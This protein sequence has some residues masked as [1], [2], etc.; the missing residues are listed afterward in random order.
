MA[1]AMP[2]IDIHFIVHYGL[3]FFVVLAFILNGAWVFCRF[4]AGRPNRGSG[5]TNRRVG[6]VDVVRVGEALCW[7][8]AMMSNISY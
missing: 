4:S 8:G 5:Y 3:A 7:S 6:S 2:E 1:T